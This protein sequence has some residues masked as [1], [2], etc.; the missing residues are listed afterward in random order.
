[1]SGGQ[2]LTPRQKA[3]VNRFYEHADTRTIAALQELVSDL[4]V[5]DPASK[6]AAKKWGKAATLL[7]KTNVTPAQISR[8]VDAK[9][10]K[11]FAE[12]IG[13]LSK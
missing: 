10:V 3:I 12:L 5:A 1:M 7:A 6:D 2:Y 13:T 8:V 9:N 4:A 11:A